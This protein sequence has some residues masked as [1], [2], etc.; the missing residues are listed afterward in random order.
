MAQHKDCKNFSGGFCKLKEKEVP[1]DGPA[2]GA[3]ENKEE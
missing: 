3:F 2:C 1:A